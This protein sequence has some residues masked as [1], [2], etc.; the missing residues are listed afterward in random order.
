[1]VVAA[2]TLFAWPQVLFELFIYAL[3]FPANDKPKSTEKNETSDAAE[4]ALTDNL[5]S[6]LK[7][8]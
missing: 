2:L 1:M 6:E 7:R 8:K 3:I 5:G 4:K